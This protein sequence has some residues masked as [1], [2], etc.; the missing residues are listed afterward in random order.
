MDVS[1][2][3]IIPGH[4]CGTTERIPVYT[5]RRALQRERAVEESPMGYYFARTLTLTFENALDHLQ[6]ALRTE[7]FGVMTEIDLQDTFSRL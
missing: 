7:G 6:E 1:Q 2:D 4:D 3:V 5:S